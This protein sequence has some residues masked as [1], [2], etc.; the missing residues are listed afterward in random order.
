MTTYWPSV[1]LN[2]A[3]SAV[4]LAL[5]CRQTRNDCDTAWRP[6]MDAA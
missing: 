3:R 6:K 1:H 5:M 4:R 2:A